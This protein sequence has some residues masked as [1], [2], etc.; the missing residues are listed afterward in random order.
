[1]WP[2]PKPLTPAPAIEKRRSQLSHALT[3]AREGS[4][5]PTHH[6][7]VQ[8]PV[9]PPGV[10][11]TGHTAGV[12]MDSAIPGM[13]NTW[14]YMMNGM[15]DAVGFPGYQYLAMLATRSEFQ[16]MV[17]RLSIELTREWIVL[18]SSETAG[19][20]TK[21]KITEL[22]QEL[23][24]LGLQ[25]VIQTAA[26]HDGYF[27]R[28]QIFI[29]LKGH[30]NQTPLI[31]DSRTIGKD[32]FRGVKTV[33]AMW[34]TPVAW[35]A[36]NPVAPDF[37]KPSQ[38]WMLGQQVHASR[39]MTIITRPLPDMLK[40]AFNF[41]GMSLTQLAEPY[42]DNWIRTRRSVS[43]LISNFSVTALATSMDQVLTGGDDGTDLFKRAELFT[44]TRNNRGL[45]LL[46]KDREELVQV[47]TPLS[48][49]SELQSQAEEHMGLPSG[50]PMIVL[51]GISPTGLNASSEGEIRVWYD[52]IAAMQES[53]WRVPIETVLKVMQ[54]S[55]YGKIDPDITFAFKPLFQLTAQEEADVLTSKSTSACNYIDRGVLDPSEERERL[56]RDPDSGYE[57]LDLS[58]EPQLPEPDEPEETKGLTDGNNSD[59]KK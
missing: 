32:S 36:L 48:G 13:R 24:T 3:L 57:G 33:E 5:V 7:P 42:V 31:L 41:S 22:T 28:G 23:K 58:V 46:D 47:N 54:L 8:P 30:D 15:R 53:N 45:M 10:V 34:T 50:M 18:N 29:D 20:G 44:L 4:N 2:F 26:E 19:D 56:A 14:A 39:L 12:A 21:E 51:T 52:L 38:W 17:S 6:F 1:M 27:G 43:D 9:L 11:P 25:K 49:L 40:P 55:M 59:A 16:K 35:N 37:Y